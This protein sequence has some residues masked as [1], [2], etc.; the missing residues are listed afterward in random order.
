MR[1]RA[2][3]VAGHALAPA[4][5]APWK[6]H[7]IAAALS[8]PALINRLA[9]ALLPYAQSGCL[10]IVGFEGERSLV[11]AEARAAE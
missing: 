1:A 10:L 2:G 5:S 3:A 7:A 8:R 6:K 9:S 4:A 11:D